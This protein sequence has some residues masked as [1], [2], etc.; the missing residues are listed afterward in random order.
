MIEKEQGG[1]SEWERGR[2]FTHAEQTFAFLW[3]SRLKTPPGGGGGQRWRGFLAKHVC[4]VH[5]ISSFMCTEMSVTA[6]DLMCE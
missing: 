1:K 6:W 2:M 3:F 5:L 4:H